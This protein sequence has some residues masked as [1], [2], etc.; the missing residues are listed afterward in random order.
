MV[1]A[2]LAIFMKWCI[3]KFIPEVGIGY[4]I[5][6]QSVRVPVSHIVVHLHLWWDLTIR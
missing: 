1:L 4:D 3:V 5:M 2:I 6:N